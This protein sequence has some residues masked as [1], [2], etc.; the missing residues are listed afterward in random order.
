MSVA[1]M[2]EPLAEI[3]PAV[4]HPVLKKTILELLEALPAGQSVRK[5]QEK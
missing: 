4:H 1:S 5:Y 2:L 3:A